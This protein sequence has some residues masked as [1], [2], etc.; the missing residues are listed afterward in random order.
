MTP[1]VSPNLMRLARTAL[2]S[3]PGRFCANLLNLSKFL[4]Y[5]K[6]LFRSS[7]VAIQP[8]HR[9]WFPAANDRT[10][11][12]ASPFDSASFAQRKAFKQRPASLEPLGLA[13]KFPGLAM[14]L[15]SEGVSYRGR[16]AL[17]RPHPTLR[18]GFPLPFRAGPMAT[19]RLHRS[20]YSLF[21]IA[22]AIPVCN[23]RFFLLLAA[24]CSFLRI[25]T[26]RL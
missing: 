2:F 11:H 10:G 20:I 19:G 5:V 6:L 9:G 3:A 26:A 25:A 16:G 8:H 12:P 14:V 13:G 17:N 23:P 24:C 7:F 4:L 15:F 22:Q 1:G 21:R 18:T